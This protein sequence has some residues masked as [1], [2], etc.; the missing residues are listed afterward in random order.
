MDYINGPLSKVP[1]EEIQEGDR[2]LGANGS[3]GKITAIIPIA[4]ASRKEDNEFVIDWDN[5]NQSIVWHFWC[6][7]VTYLGRP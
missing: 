7:K 5:G 3:E 6:D 1:F 4:E 2:L